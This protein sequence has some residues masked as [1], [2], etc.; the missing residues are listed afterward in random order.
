LLLTIKGQGCG[1]GAQE[2]MDGPA[3]LCSRLSGP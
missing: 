2:N 3:S 1:V